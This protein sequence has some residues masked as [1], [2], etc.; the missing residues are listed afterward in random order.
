MPRNEDGEFE[1]VV[2]NKQ[3]RSVF[4]IVV[5]LI[6]VFFTMGYIVGRN[7]GPGGDNAVAKRTTTE[8]PAPSLPGPSPAGA[9]VATESYGPPAQPQPAWP[10]LG[11]RDALS[12]PRPQAARP[13]RGSDWSFRI[14]AKTGREN[15]VS[16]GGPTWATTWKRP[17]VKRWQNSMSLP[18]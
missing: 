10:G 11:C 15:R 2:G 13:R 5:I 9:P 14:T 6:G 18:N 12:V 1:L 8:S 7:S 4:F 17:A 3:L 16:K